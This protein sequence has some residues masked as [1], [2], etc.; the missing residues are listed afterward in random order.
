MTLQSLLTL[1]CLFLLAQRLCYTVLPV[2]YNIKQIAL[3]YVFQS[4]YAQLHLHPRLKQEMYPCPSK[5]SLSCRQRQG[6]VDQHLVL[7]Q[8]SVYLYPW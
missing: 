8:S 1:T 7:E 3:W 5:E 4:I 2:V 6:E